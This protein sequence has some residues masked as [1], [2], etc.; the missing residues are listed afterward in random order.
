MTHATVIRSYEPRI[1]HHVSALN[2]AVH[3]QAT[4]GLSTD[5]NDL[6]C[7]FTFDTMGDFAFGRD[8]GLLTGA[9]GS[10]EAYYSSDMKSASNHRSLREEWQSATEML[11]PLNPATWVIGFGQ[12]FFPFLKQS[13][14]FRRLIQF[15]HSEIHDRIRVSRVRTSKWRSLRA[16]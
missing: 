10:E 16:R 3:R 8:F 9:E 2:A 15:C 4:A 12:T 13:Q 11:G 5:L 7:R 6:I 1:L 14:D